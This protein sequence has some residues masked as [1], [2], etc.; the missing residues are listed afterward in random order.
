MSIIDRVKRLFS[1][2]G[3]TEDTEDA[4]IDKMASSREGQA[5]TQSEGGSIPPGYLPTGVD[6][7]RPKK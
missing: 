6:E 7:H 3:R 5:L 2:E 1:S 4:R